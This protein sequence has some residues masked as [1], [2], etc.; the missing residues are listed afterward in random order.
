MAKFLRTKCTKTC[1]AHFLQ[2]GT[3]LAPFIDH[4]FT[5]RMHDEEK[6]DR[7]S[8]DTEDVPKKPRFALRHYTVTEVALLWRLSDDA[9]RAL[10]ENEPG[11]IVFG[12][13]R[14]GR[15]RYRTIRIPE[16]VLERVHRKRT[17]QYV[18][19]SVA[20]ANRLSK[21]PKKL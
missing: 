17:S 10:F 18:V 8:K 21:T 13:Q 12:D 7:D 3:A 4:A 1:P 19:H 15:R 6:V 20:H 16:D 2:E 11:V 5:L 14:P 9:I